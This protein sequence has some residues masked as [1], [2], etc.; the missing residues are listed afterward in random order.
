MFQSWYPSFLSISANCTSSWKHVHADNKV[1]TMSNCSLLN[2]TM[3]S[4]NTTDCLTWACI[5]GA[6]TVNMWVARKALSHFIGI[7][8]FRK[9]LS[10]SARHYPLLQGITPFRKALSP[11]ARHYPLPQSITPF[12]KALSPSAR[13]YPLPQGIISFHMALSPSARHYPLLQGI[14]PFRKALS[15]SARHYPLLQG[16]IPFPKTSSPFHTITLDFLCICAF[17][18]FEQCNL[19]LDFVA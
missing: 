12:R 3:D 16:I 1:H 10:P 18:H 6:N 2:M 5:H 19:T 13:H 14:I 9:A 11:S 15:S 7:M 17:L 4:E 8:P